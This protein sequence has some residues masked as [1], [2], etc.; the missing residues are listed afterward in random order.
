MLI[1]NIPRKRDPSEQEKGVLVTPKSGGLAGGPPPGPITK[2]TVFYIARN[3]R[4]I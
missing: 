1:Q 3:H 2:V 4:R